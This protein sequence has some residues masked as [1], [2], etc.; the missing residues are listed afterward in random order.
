[1]NII[2]TEHGDLIF[3]VFYD[4]EQH[5]FGPILQNVI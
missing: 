5:Y 4:C 3:G 2:K 1:M